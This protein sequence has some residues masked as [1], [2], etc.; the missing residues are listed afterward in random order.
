MTKILTISKPY[1][2]ASYR[3][4]LS[5]LAG[6]PDLEVGLI[7]PPQWG[8]QKWEKAREKEPFWTRTLPIRWNG[9]N[10]FHVYRGLPDAVRAFRPDI[11]N[12]EEE[13]YSLV[14][15][16]ACRLARKL[17]IPAAFYTWQNIYKTYPLPF[18]WVERYVFESCAVGFAGNQ[19]AADVLR[20]KGYRGKV[21]VVPQMGVTYE[22]FAPKADE[23]ARAERKRRLRLAPDRFTVAFI[24]RLVEEKGVQTLLDALAKVSDQTPVDV[25]ILGDGPY[26]SALEEQALALNLRD[27]VRF[28]AA[29]PS[30]EVA[31]Y[32]K[33]VDA[34][35]LPSLTRPNWKEQFGRVLVE[36]MAAEAV[37]IGSSSGEIP[38]VVGDAGRIF[39]E[40][41]VAALAGLIGELASDAELC[42]ELVRRGRERVKGCYTNQVIART[43][44]AAFREMLSH[45]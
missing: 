28:I 9:K 30:T 43:F 8:T 6:E 31:A 12:I 39:Q 33:A 18:R 25:L 38:H 41:D 32:L 19:E 42:R 4:K 23:P 29:V 17:G 40:G 7:A 1:V 14:T 13:H 37:V 24:G 15:L 35:C 27:R 5:L 45:G 11:L 36:A 2:A 10:H 21:V 44:A 20:A 16:Q 22:S 3:S 34:L 26:R